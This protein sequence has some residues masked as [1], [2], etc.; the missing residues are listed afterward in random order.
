M[1]SIFLWLITPQEA[2]IAVTIKS[3]IE[4]DHEARSEITRS[5]MESMA[6]LV[7]TEAEVDM[8]LPSLQALSDDHF[9][10][11]PNEITSGQV[12]TLEHDADRL[13]RITN[14]TLNKGKHA[15]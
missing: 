3:E 1:G 6:A 13:K 8:M 2:F 11:S 10:Y 4:N 7:S 5:K 12:G 9:G 14:M 15:A